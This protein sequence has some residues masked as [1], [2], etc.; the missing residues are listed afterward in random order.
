MRYMAIMCFFSF[1]SSILGTVE[2]AFRI[3]KSLRPGL[4]VL[5]IERCDDT[6]KTFWQLDVH[7]TDGDSFKLNIAPKCLVC[8]AI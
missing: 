2:G 5:R 1:C 6:W 7:F 8:P 4:S 3:W